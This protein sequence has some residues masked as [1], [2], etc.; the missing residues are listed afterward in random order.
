MGSRKAATVWKWDGC[1]RWVQKMGTMVERP[2]QVQMH[3][4]LESVSEV[5]GMKGTIIW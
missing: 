3:S 1:K 2:I 5:G 4:K